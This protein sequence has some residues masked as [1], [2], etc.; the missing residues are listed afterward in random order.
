[1]SAYTPTA[2]T[3][4]KRDDK[5]MRVTTVSVTI[6]TGMEPAL[7]KYVASLWVNQFKGP[8]VKTG[9]RVWERRQGGASNLTKAP[10]DSRDSSSRP[11][12]H[13]STIS[14][15]HSMRP[16]PTVE[17]SVKCLKRSLT[18]AYELRK[19]ANA[20]PKSTRDE[21]IDRVVAIEE[22][23]KA[24]LAESP[25]TIAIRDRRRADEK[26]AAEKALEIERA[27]QVKRER[28]EAIAAREKQDAIDAKQRLIDAHDRRE[29]EMT[30]V[31][32]DFPYPPYRRGYMVTDD[33]YMRR[34]EGLE[35]RDTYSEA[36]YEWCMRYNNSIATCVR[37]VPL[38]NVSTHP[39]KPKQP[40]GPAFTPMA[41]EYECYEPSGS[42]HEHDRA[43]ERRDQTTISGG[44][45]ASGY[46]QRATR[47]K[48]GP[49]P[50]G[51]ARGRKNGKRGGQTA[52]RKPR[53]S[54][55]DTY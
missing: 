9:P 28:E 19:L 39:A 37:K 40:T 12:S 48:R 8:A 6:P 23:V 10:T 53:D 3:R 41:E 13:A 5:Q 22:S 38:L 11:H 4:N 52:G 55:P 45:T 46:S 15:A 16:I 17:P 54:N 2:D 31:T 33:D 42:D 14:A 30:A 47:P 50:K 51:A 43:E 20:M 25:T 34:L 32:R 44:A 18:D 27:A 29:E 26:R 1:M 49:Y 35:P 21:V 36:H 24:K 7:Y